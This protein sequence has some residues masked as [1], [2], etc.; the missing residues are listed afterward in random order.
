MATPWVLG[1]LV[2]AA[3]VYRGPTGG[4]A[5]VTPAALQAERSQATPAV[6]TAP[7]TDLRDV[8]PV[9]SLISEFL[10]GPT[11][12]QDVVQAIAHMRGELSLRQLPT[13]DTNQA[14]KALDVLQRTLA[15]RT[16]AE[17]TDL[18][19]TD[20]DDAFKLLLGLRF[21][22]RDPLS[23]SRQRLIDYLG[24]IINARNLVEATRVQLQ[25]R[26]NV[27]FV[28]ATIPDYVDSQGRWAFDDVASMIQSAAGASDFVLDRF[29]LPDWSPTPATAALTGRDHERQPGALLFRQV[30]ALAEGETSK[31]H[32]AKVLAVLLVGETATNGVHKRA[33]ASAVRLVTTW[34][35]GPPCP[36][37]GPPRPPTENDT[38]R[39][40]AACPVKIL[41]PSFSGSTPSVRLTLE[42]VARTMGERQLRVDVVTGSA[43]SGAN[44]AMMRLGVTDGGVPLEQLDV[45]F[46][47]T[48]HTDDVM[49]Q[50]LASYLESEDRRWRCGQGVALL[51][52]GNTAWGTGLFSAGPRAA[53]ADRAHG[54]PAPERQHP[55]ADQSNTP[56]N[57]YVPDFP[58][59]PRALRLYFPLH[60]SRVRSASGEGGPRVNVPQFGL[61]ISPGATLRLDDTAT[62]ADQIPSFTPQLTAATVEVALRNIL[63]SL[64]LEHIGAVGIFATDK[65]DHLFLAREI[66]RAAPNVLMFTTEPHLLMLQRDYGAYVRGTIV[67]STYPLFNRTQLLTAGQTFQRR[68]FASMAS[69]GTY[70][71]MLALLGRGNDMV[72]YGAPLTEPR[73]IARPSVWLSVTGTDA[74]WPLDAK[75][76]GFEPE[77]LLDPAAWT[78]HAVAPERTGVDTAAAE[79][80]AAAVNPDERQ[81]DV[82]SGA[83]RATIGFALLLLAVVI[84]HLLILGIILA[85]YYFGDSESSSSLGAVRPSRSIIDRVRRGS[86]LGAFRP[87]GIHA[88]LTTPAIDRLKVKQHEHRLLVACCALALLTL[89]LTVLKL[90]LVYSQ[91]GRPISLPVAVVNPDV[92]KTLTAVEPAPVIWSFMSWALVLVGAV[93]VVWVALTLV[94]VLWPRLQ[95]FWKAPEH[96]RRDP[97]QTVAAFLGLATSLTIVYFLWTD[98]V[99]NRPTTALLFLE[100]TLNVSN[101]VSPAPLLLA[102]GTIGYAWG[103]WSLHGLRDHALSL[104]DDAPILK[105]LAGGDLHLQRQLAAGLNSG[106]PP[107]GGFAILPYLGLGIAVAAGVDRTQALEGER[108]RVLML[109]G[110]AFGV[111]VIAVILGQSAWLGRRLKAALERLRVHPLSEAMSDVAKEPLDWGL[112]LEPNY[113]TARLVLTARMR[114]LT[115]TLK[116]LANGFCDGTE[117]PKL[118]ASAASRTCDD[119]LVAAPMPRSQ[120]QLACLEAVAD[121]LGVRAADLAWVQNWESMIGRRPKPGES[122]HDQR[123]RALQG[124]GAALVRTRLWHTATHVVNHLIPGLDRGYWT[125]PAPPHPTNVTLWYKRGERVVGLYVALLIR[126][127]LSRVTSGLTVA[128]LLGMVL[129]LGHLFYTFP[130]RPFWLLFDL[131]VLTITGIV[132]ASL[133]L[134]FDRDSI[135]SRL[136]S[137]EPGKISWSSGFVYRAAS[138]IALPLLTLFALRF[139][140]VGGRLLGW[141]EP[142]R[143]IL[144]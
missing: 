70:N 75:F 74:F 20:R 57:A 3:V 141:I 77:F 24:G 53:A 80:P 2:A 94:A 63:A 93:I 120:E 106:I 119:T 51:I 18:T 21:D 131:G 116:L 52:E 92:P 67:A 82:Y 30:A 84:G 110:S 121:A 13:S 95:R 29:Y 54:Q 35:T 133:L 125:P 66:N 99:W 9:V 90:A 72:D 130:G 85:R 40:P 118:K 43:T 58:V 25:G 129:F 134:S 117:R 60:I 113:A 38:G 104:G 91:D 16:P 37:I 88:Q 50:A 56:V 124:D 11:A 103:Y 78:E 46:F 19:T 17:K 55:C 102:F 101:F 135:L 69:Q 42:D 112:S 136:W 4:E 49:L 139:P 128:L 65:R 83:S 59:L 138:Y 143:Q 7:E 36:V 8:L 122:G 137:T 44:A 144:P 27:D 89:G 115:E 6:A 71:A 79:D 31:E 12:P 140:E 5:P 100:R 68:Q 1:L 33:L 98:P 32:V 64:Q 15:P 22:S 87:P 111:F 105:L 132:G 107:M 10:G 81:T 123:R 73:N 97:T 114:K 126:D 96:A 45:R 76:D 61:S 34:Q 28:I 127:V 26:A 86:W 39:P 47:A 108:F 41:G 109:T 48:V 142:V 62:P 23:Q 14:L